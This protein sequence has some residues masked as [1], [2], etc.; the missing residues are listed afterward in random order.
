LPQVA[1]LSDARRVIDGASMRINVTLANSSPS[2][3][4]MA[5]LKV[6]RAASGTHVLPVFYEDNYISLVGGEKRSL[7]LTFAIADL[8]GDEPRLSVEGWNIVPSNVDL[9]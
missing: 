6:T 1:L 8:K 7:S 4:L 5:R 3:A 9:R 2:V